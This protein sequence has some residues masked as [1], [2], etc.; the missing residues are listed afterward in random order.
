MHGDAESLHLPLE[1][2]GA[3]FS[4]RRERPQHWLTHQLI[5]GYRGRLEI[6]YWACCD[7]RCRCRCRSLGGGN[8]AIGAVSRQAT[9]TRTR[10]ELVV[11]RF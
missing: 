11:T 3:C 7:F 1:R 10:A 6:K 2:P 4:D 5:G 9:S 8:Q